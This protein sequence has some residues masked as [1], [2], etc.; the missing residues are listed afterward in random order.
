MKTE[1]QKPALTLAGEF[2]KGLESGEYPHPENTL[3][4]ISSIVRKSTEPLIR[5][6]WSGYLCKLTPDQMNIEP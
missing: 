3:K 2:Q 5:A 1:T 6:Y 4:A